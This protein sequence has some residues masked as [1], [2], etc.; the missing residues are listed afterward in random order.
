MSLG[1]RTNSSLG[2]GVVGAAGY[3]GLV[4]SVGLAAVGHRVIGVDVNE[5]A[6]A[7]LQ[8]GVSPIHEEGLLPALQATTRSGR[9]RFTTSLAEALPP[10]DVIFIAVGTPSREDGHADLSQVIAVAENLALHLDKYMVVVVKSTVPVGTVELVRSVLG[11]RKRE[12]EDFD[13]VANPEFLREGKGLVD[14]FHPDRIVVGASSQRALSVVRTLYEPI[15]NRTVPGGDS[16][17]R[18]EPVPLVETDVASAQMIK[19]A[20]N[21]FLAMRISFINEIA[22]FCDRFGSDVHE[23]ARGLGFDARI[24]PAYLDAGLGFGGPCLEKD[25]RALIRIA[26][27]TRYEPRLLRAVL[28]R[29]EQQLREIVAKIK[30]AVGYLLYGRI[31]AVFG[32][33]FKAGT[34]DL[35]NSLALRLIAELER[36]GALVRSYDPLAALPGDASGG[37]HSVDDPYEAVERADVLVIATEWPEFRELDYT[38]IRSRMAQ[39]AI[40]DARNLLDARVMRGLGYRYVGVGVK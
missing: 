29:N 34:N 40:V 33:A 18:R 30:G 10:V 36:E 28:D 17:D 6:V 21:S 26:E 5:E 12:G 35:R 23:V 16:G 4:T 1:K 3:V 39:P 20:A 19:Y 31:V 13:I 32:R 14:F 8:N 2:V 25:L 7:G 38:R 27:E 15:L 37:G 9:L 24:G 22:A 11:R